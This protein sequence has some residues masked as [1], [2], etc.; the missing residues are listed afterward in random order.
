[1][2]P[3]LSQIEFVALMAMMVSTIAFSIDAMLPAL[4][5]IGTELS[6]GFENRAQLI[7]TTF[8]LGMGL[9]TL[10]TGMLSDRYGRKPVLM[11]GAVVYVLAS[12]VAWAAHSLELML[13]ARL[14]QGL[15]AAGPRIV[16]LAIIRDLYAGRGMAKIMSFIMMVF[17][18]VPALAP[19]MGAFLIAHS[20]WRAIFVAFVVFMGLAC[21]WMAL[22]LPETL[23]AEDRRP[24]RVSA[25]KQ[26]LTE[27]AMHPTVRL[28]I[29]VQTLCFGI[30][31]SM[32]S[33]VQQIYD[34]TFGRGAEFPFWFGI[35]A[36]L[37]GTGSLLNAALVGRMGMRFLV[38]MTLAVQVGLSGVMVFL[39]MVDLP[40]NLGFF[41]F[42][43]W[44]ISVF[45]QAGMTLGNLNALA[46]EPMGHIAGTAASV[47]GAVSTVFSVALAI[48]LGLMFDGTTLPLSLGICVMALASLLVML[49]MRRVER[50]LPA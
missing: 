26:A 29:I 6:P 45:F 1:M 12:A 13:A 46:M 38:T 50:G 15:G 21:L 34:I 2:P 9:G 16:T 36:V 19:L 27:L 39:S 44:Q 37:A 32:L 31:F 14:V 8:V 28:S 48:P 3:R 17:T 41:A 5:E 7:L 20:G 43:V 42:V 18:L 4:P 23:P 40:S 35:V 49:H 11:I 47:I 30:L 24:M 33:S 25:L 10:V 22:R